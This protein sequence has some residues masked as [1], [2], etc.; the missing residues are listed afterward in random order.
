MQV[1]WEL[2]LGFEVVVEPDPEPSPTPTCTTVVGG[3]AK[4]SVARTAS[5]PALD[6]IAGMASV[7]SVRKGKKIKVQKSAINQ[8]V[9]LKIDT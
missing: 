9:D 6:W 3:N 8:H 5:R 1:E 2:A 7:I 4:P